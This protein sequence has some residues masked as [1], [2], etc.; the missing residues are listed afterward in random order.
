ML[1]NVD[2]FCKDYVVQKAIIEIVI[3][4]IRYEIKFV[5][6]IHQ[7]IVFCIW[8]QINSRYLKIGCDHKI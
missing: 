4:F 7:T 6:N 1:I 2:N 3:K 8:W 5:N